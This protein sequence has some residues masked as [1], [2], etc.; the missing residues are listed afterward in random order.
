MR[1][2]LLLAALAAACA[3]GCTEQ[4]SDIHGT[5]KHKGKPLK[6]GTIIIVA[7]DNQTHR[8]Y[9]GPDGSY[10]IT[11]VARG[12]VQVAVIVEGPRVPPR[13]E[14][15]PGADPDAVAK[16]IAEDEARRANMKGAAPAGPPIPPKYA[17]A[18]TSGLGFELKEADQEFSPDLQ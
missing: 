8:A 10:R 1:S 9:L 3:T 11:G 7:P 12:P 16:A 2:I 13:P 15:K 14:P 6:A 18:A 4:R 17:D 5:V